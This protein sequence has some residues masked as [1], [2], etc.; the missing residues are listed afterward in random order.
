M[1]MRFCQLQAIIQTS[2]DWNLLVGSY[3]RWVN[4]M[5]SLYSNVCFWKFSESSWDQNFG[6]TKYNQNWV[7]KH[8]TTPVVNRTI[9]LTETHAGNPELG[10]L[11]LMK[12]LAL[13]ATPARLKHRVPHAQNFAYFQEV[14][15]AP[16]DSNA[17]ASAQEIEI[18]AVD[19]VLRRN[20]AFKT[21][22]RRSSNLPNL[23]TLWSHTW[24]NI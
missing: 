13:G 16:L 3:E 7:K 15:A 4:F 6:A 2:F 22:R 18:P 20:F 1:I 11:D 12:S 5:T 24:K 23:K 21:L 14:D 10:S 19:H 8:I 9:L 17:T